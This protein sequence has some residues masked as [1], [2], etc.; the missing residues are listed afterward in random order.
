MPHHYVCVTLN[1]LN[2]HDNFAVESSCSIDL[3]LAKETSS[4]DSPG[5]FKFSRLIESFVVEKERIST[6]TVCCWACESLVMGLSEAMA[7]VVLIGDA[8]TVQQ[9]IFVPGATS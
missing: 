8:M 9:V 7:T 3:H 4:K 5:A 2:I 6:W 1:L